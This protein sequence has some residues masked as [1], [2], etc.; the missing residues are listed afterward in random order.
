MNIFNIN[1]LIDTFANYLIL[2]VIEVHTNIMIICNINVVYNYIHI[3]I[4]LNQ[5]IMFYLE[6]MNN[7][8]TSSF[9]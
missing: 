6:L 1:N 5:V 8:S 3:Y 7:L 2:L 9:N 4:L